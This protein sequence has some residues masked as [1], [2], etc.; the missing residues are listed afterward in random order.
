MVN[1]ASL[2]AEKRRISKKN[3]C[4]N[5]NSENLM[6]QAKKKLYRPLPIDHI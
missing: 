1:V 6:N 4:A 3:I 5:I 2:L